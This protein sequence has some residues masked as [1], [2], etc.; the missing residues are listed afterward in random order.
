MYFGKCTRWT[1]TFHVS[2]GFDIQVT[3]EFIH[4]NVQWEKQELQ[5][6]QG[7]CKVSDMLIFYQDHIRR[8]SNVYGSDEHT[9]CLNFQ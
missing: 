2:S 1:E 3:E 5:R 8:P 9:S 4:I 7:I 6:F